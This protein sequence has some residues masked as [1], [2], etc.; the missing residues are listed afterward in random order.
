MLELLEKHL[1]NMGVFDSNLPDIVKSIAN[2]IPSTTIPYRM[3]L[4]FAISEIILYASQFKINIQHWNHSVIPVNAITF[5]IAKSG[6]SKDSS[7]KAARKCFK[8][9]YELIEEKR[10]E[11]AKATAIEMAT[12]AG[13]E[14]PNIWKA[15]GQYYI[16]PNP[17]FVAPSTVEGFIQHLNDL[18]TTGLGAG[19]IYSGELG[20]EIASNSVIVDNIKILAELYDEGTKE[21]KVL[22]DRTN[23]SREIK[24]L[25]VSALFMGSQDNILFDDNIKKRF[26]TEFTTK[27]ARRSFFIFANED[28]EQ[29]ESFSVIEMLEKQKALEDKAIEIRVAVEEYIE[30]LTVHLLENKNT[31]LEVDPEVRDL[32]IIYQ[33]Y[34]EEVAKTID[35]SL[36]ITKLTRTHLHWKCLKLSGA[37]AIIHGRDT[38]ELTDYKAAIEF[39]ELINSD[40]SYFERELVKEPYEVFTDY[41]K[42]NLINNET[43]VGL[44]TLRK[45]GFIPMKGGNS[46]LKMKELVQLATSYDNSGVYSCTNEGIHYQ[47]LNK[48]NIVLLSYVPVSGTKIQRHKQCA[49]GYVCEELL[50]E[51]IGNM[52]EGDYA[53]S[54]FR[55]IEGVRGRDNIDSPCKWV[56]L[57]VDTSDITDEEAHILLSDINHY[58]VRTSNKNN[59][60]KFRILIELDSEVDIPH[61][62]WKFFIHSI[63]NE[64]GIVVDELPKS[65]IFYS[66]KDRNI[67][68]TLN[69]SP[70]S[71]QE[72]VAYAAVKAAE[73]LTDTVEKP[74]T[75][76]QKNALLDDMYNTFAPAFNAVS[77]EGSRKLI[78]AARKAKELGADKEYVL[79]LVNEINNYWIV[80]LNETRF[81]N[82]ILNQ[83]KRWNF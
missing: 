33:K 22:K 72:H 36:P 44:H 30:N 18:D 15:Y 9:G 8:A 17:L 3:K 69:S 68:S 83:I 51:D 56:V 61:D 12:E 2:S 27:L 54:P 45:M 62:Q 40:I 64:I 65:Q 81:T 49:K 58:I 31:Y 14:V 19:Y 39:V 25:P 41:V 26:K 73:K 11:L 50:F 48:T 1:R 79:N 57:D 47:K 77:G 29:E 5:G 53:Y 16:P 59:E 55:F 38:I 6:A 13:E 35:N 34:N 24:G 75:K 66:Y 80:P 63:S 52:L 78:W 42:N 23:Q 71:A 21:V 32:S 67:L 60:F 20:A 82:T 10:F 43:F 76:V 37:F 7:I 70:L 74:L 46:T 4:A 28:I